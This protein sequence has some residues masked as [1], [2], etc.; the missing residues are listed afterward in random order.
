MKRE[1]ALSI[2][3]VVLLATVQGAAA[4]TRYSGTV[5]AVHPDARTL[6]I[7]VMGPWTGG[8]NSMKDV[9]VRVGDDAT[10][11]Q[12]ERASGEQVGNAGWPGGYKD[13]PTTL[14]D[15]KPGDD[16]TVTGDEQNGG[17]V[18]RHLTI[19]VPDQDVM[20]SPKTELPQPVEK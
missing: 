11:D 10:I 15:V 6:T 13:Q 16:A 7:Q 18:A 14:L 12:V 20:A 4:E 9:T 5:T 17:F 1:V 2:V 8:R 19:V 3:V